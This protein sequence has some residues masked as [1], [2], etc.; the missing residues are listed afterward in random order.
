MARDREYEK[1]VRNYTRF[2]VQ[3]GK[4]VGGWEYAEDAK[5]ELRAMKEEGRLGDAKIVARAS[6]AKYGIDPK[7][8]F[9]TPTKKPDL[10]VGVY[11][12]GIV[13]ADKS[14]EV[15]GD[16]ARCAFLD[17]ATLTL[18]FQNDCPPALRAEITRH[19]ATIQ[20]KRGEQFATSSSG[21]TVML[22][23]SAAKHESG[24]NP[25]TRRS[26]KRDRRPVQPKTGFVHRWGTASAK[27]TRVLGVPLSP[28]LKGR[29]EKLVGGKK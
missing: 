18:K 29:I 22:G 16:Y 1:Q 8:P 4:A 13:Y 25:S 27:R 2:I 15:H 6:L 20:A 21:Q 26:K 12:A 11:P 14:R 23:P 19:A 28:G 9:A 5:D 17:Y 7:R 3:N 10:F 24:G